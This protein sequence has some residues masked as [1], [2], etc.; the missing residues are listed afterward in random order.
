MKFLIREMGWDAW[1]A[2]LER[3]LAEVR[4]EGGSRLP[5]DP[6]DPPVEA[7]PAWSRA[8]PPSLAETAARAT[9]TEMRGP[10]FRPRV[11][12][13]LRAPPPISRAGP[14]R[15]CARR[16]RRATRSRP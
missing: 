13:A 9:A 16:S 6:E 8:K 1:R 14:A 10:G 11:E 7:A 3:T 4:A 2:E 5:F 12:P 15:T